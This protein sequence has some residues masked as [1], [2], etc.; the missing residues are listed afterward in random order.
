M[1]FMWTLKHIPELKAFSAKERR[2]I[3]RKAYKKIKNHKK[4]NQGTLLI[5]LFYG[6]FFYIIYNF[7]LPQTLI[8][9]I[10]VAGILGLIF[11][12]IFQQFVFNYSRPYIQEIISEKR[13]KKND[14]G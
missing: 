13:N 12:I 3:W 9:G 1:E 8:N 4:L 2:R 10:I 7:L 11:G 14:S 5:F 6:A